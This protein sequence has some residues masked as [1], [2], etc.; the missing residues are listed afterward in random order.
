M[1]PIAR[2]RDAGSFAAHP[3]LYRIDRGNPSSCIWFQDLRFVTP[4]RDVVP[5]R[6]GLCGEGPGRWTP[7]LL[8]GDARIPVR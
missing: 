6:Y 5:F 4:G 7:F 8:D 3:A 2:E 1:H